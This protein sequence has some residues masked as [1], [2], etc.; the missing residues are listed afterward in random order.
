MSDKGNKVV[1]KEAV[2]V[3]FAGDSGDGMQLTGSQFSD[4]AA[5]AG[6][7]LATF[8]DFPSEIRAPQGT[9]AGVSGFQVH[10]GKEIHTS[11]DQ[12]DVLV[13]L[14]PAALR[15]NMKWVKPGATIIIDVDNFDDK[16]Y[17]KAG[18]GEDPLEDQTLDGY[19]VVKAPITSLTRAS[20]KEF[21][22]DLKT[23]DKTK[24]QFASGLLF[25]LFNRDISIGE[26]F[27]EEKFAKKPILVEANKTVLHSGYNYAETIEALSTTYHIPALEGKK[28]MYRN[29]TG[30]VATAW[31]LIAAAEKAKLP[32]FLGSYPI[33][34]ATEILQELS[35]HKNLNVRTFQ[36]EDEIAGVTSAIGASF[37]GNF[38]VTTT[39]GPGLSLKSEAIG[40]A[41]ITE[42]PLVIVDV[43]RGGPATGLPTKPEQSDLLQALYGRNGESPVV[44]IAASTPANC[45]YYAF[46]ASKIALEHMTPVILLTDGYLANGS[47]LWAIP[48]TEDLPEI[49]APIADEQDEDYEFMPYKR[50]P[51]TLAR[52]WAFPGKVGLRHRVGGLE[53]E[54]VTGIVSHDPLNHQKMVYLRKA[55]VD[56]VVDVIPELEVYGEDEGDLLVVGWGGTYGALYS[57]V[58]DLREEG[59]KISLA[60]L[61]YIHPLPGNIK[62]IFKRFKRIMICEIN[63][64]QLAY[65]LRSTMGCFEY[66]QYNKVQGLP[67]FVSELKTKFNEMLED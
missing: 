37:A 44:V 25:W 3:K 10:V 65:H 38:A 43:Q 64:G 4:T 35:K 63:T 60:H 31:G 11:G 39:S 15:A 53:K 17:K 48:S 6:N 58:R 27:I 50:D 52:E 30:N 45:F 26:R 12:A 20:I 13:A 40:L 49:K 59:K 57:A 36:A 2:V 47:E 21:G 16:N 61:H 55:K 18:F 46:Q 7:D 9:I 67:F 14:N 51:E 22:L 33:T 66:Y 62:D 32:L 42:L 56:K 19:N 8:P 28:G 24:N 1:V 54:D 23:V 5:F 29:I 34:P 41:V